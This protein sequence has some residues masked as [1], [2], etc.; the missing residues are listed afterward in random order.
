MPVSE[1]QR[2][3]NKAQNAARKGKRRALMLEPSD[4]RMLERWKRKQQLPS[5]IATLRWLM[6]KVS[7]RGEGGKHASQH[8]S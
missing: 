6:A 8:G 7:G 2:R 3:A 1:A 5:R 4:V